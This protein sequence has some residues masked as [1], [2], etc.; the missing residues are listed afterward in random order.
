MPFAGAVTC[1]SQKRDHEAKVLQPK[2]GHFCYFITSRVVIPMQH[3]AGPL[4]SLSKVFLEH[5]PHSVHSY[6]SAA[7]CSNPEELCWV[8]E[9]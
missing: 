4:P 3:Q 8:A 2:E 1:L 5:L 9:W 7:Q 6:S